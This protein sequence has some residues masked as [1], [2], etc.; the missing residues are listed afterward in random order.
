MAKSVPP[1][2]LYRNYGHNIRESHANV[3][4]WNSW[5]KNET[6]GIDEQ[7]NIVGGFFLLDRQ[8]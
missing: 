7:D 2:E 1:V 4:K 5:Y 8:V 6:N 3:C